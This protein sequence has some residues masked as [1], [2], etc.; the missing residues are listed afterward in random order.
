MSSLASGLPVGNVLRGWRVTQVLSLRS[1]VRLW[2][3]SGKYD[4]VAQLGDKAPDGPWALYLA[5]S[6]HRGCW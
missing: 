5:D 3:S 6:A 4:G 1:S 2:T